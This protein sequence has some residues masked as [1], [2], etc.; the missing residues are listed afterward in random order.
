MPFNMNENLF[1][2]LGHKDDGADFSRPHGCLYIVAISALK[3]LNSI[4]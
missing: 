1:L 4:T 2:A 3:N